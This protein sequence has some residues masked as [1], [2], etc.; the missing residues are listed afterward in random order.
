MANGIQLRG[1]HQYRV[2]IRRNGVYLSETFET[3]RQAQEWQRVMEGKVTGGDVIDLKQA[4]ATTLDKACDWFLDNKLA[5]NK[6]NAKNIE[7]KLRYWKESKFA[8]WSLLAI[9]D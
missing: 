9:H 2:Q 1:S 3:L 8:A 7:A 4:Q 5:G 6:P